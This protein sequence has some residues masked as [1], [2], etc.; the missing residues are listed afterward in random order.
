MH[1]AHPRRVHAPLC[2][3]VLVAAS[4][5]YD[6]V[7]VARGLGV[8]PVPW[9]GL[10]VQLSQIQY[11][12]GSSRG[13]PEI[14]FCCGAS[15]YERPRKPSSSTHHILFHARIHAI[16]PCACARTRS[17]ALTKARTHYARTAARA[18]VQSP[19]SSVG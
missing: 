8:H 10:S 9:P 4:N 3:Q 18:Q 13:R 19:H 16:A 2:M 5:A 15:P 7:Y 11:T 12:G 1:D 6:W 17:H 14:L